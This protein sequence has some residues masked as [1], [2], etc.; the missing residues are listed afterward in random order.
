MIQYNVCYNIR[1][2]CRLETLL[3][4]ELREQVKSLV[5]RYGSYEALAR[6]IGVSWVTIQR[7]V[8]GRTN[9]SHLAARRILEV[10]SRGEEEDSNSIS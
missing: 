8:S 4:E 7:W 6:E 1:P 9:P 2:H 10:F 5:K 3:P